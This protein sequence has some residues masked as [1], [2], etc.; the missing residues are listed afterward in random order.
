MSVFIILFSSYEFGHSK[1][2]FQL[3]KGKQRFK[4]KNWCL[5]GLLNA[6]EQ[7]VVS[8]L[9]TKHSGKHDHF[10]KAALHRYKPVTS[11]LTK[12]HFYGINIHSCYYLLGWNKRQYGKI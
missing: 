7:W 2:L 8:R 11:L 1:A 12:R 9:N 10:L 6:W 5:Q 3:L 4:S